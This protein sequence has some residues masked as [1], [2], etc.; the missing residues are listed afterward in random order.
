MMNPFAAEQA[1]AE[2]ALE[3][4][5]QAHAFGGAEKGILLRDQFASDVAEVD[6]MILPG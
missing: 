5:G 4:D 2:A 1:D 3:R 6:G